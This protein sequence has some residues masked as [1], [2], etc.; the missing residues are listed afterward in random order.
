MSAHIVPLSSFLNAAN[1]QGFALLACVGVEEAGRHLVGQR[2]NFNQWQ[3]SGYGAEMSYMQRAAEHYTSFEHLL[4]GTR[5]ILCIAVPY[6]R[7]AAGP[8]PRGCGRVARY[9]WGRDYHRV[10]R[11][12]ASALVSDVLESP[13]REVFR[14]FSD[15]VPLLERALGAAGGLGFVGRNS[16]LIEPH[17]GSYHFLCEVL[18]AVEVEIDVSL[19]ELPGRARTVEAR[20]NA[21]EGCGGCRSCLPACPTAA[22]VADGVIDARRCISYLTIEK[23]TAFDAWESEAIGDWLFGCDICQDVC[24]FNQDVKHSALAQFESERGSGPFIK[25]EDVLR[26]ESDKA[27]LDRFA[28][29]PLMR[30]GRRG[31]VRNAI[32]VM[33]N[34]QWSDGA[35][36]L[37]AAAQN[38]PTEMLGRHASWALEQLLLRSDGA[39]KRRLAGVVAKLKK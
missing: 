4:P 12:A 39:E 9:A 29:T 22:I 27:Y 32:S 18:L 7:E 15:S 31:L 10:L 36:L 1:A 38:E 3:S 34:T 16:M 20:M 25:L 21:G 28:G 33:V 14:V 23:K 13:S 8:T 11:K 37:F 24:P 17:L 26:I 2:N 6:S 30:P 19:K 5:T 35:E